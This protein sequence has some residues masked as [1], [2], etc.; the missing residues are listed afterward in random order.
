MK[1]ND[2]LIVI[3]GVIILILASIGIYFWEAEELVKKDLE[4]DD[5][6]KITGKLYDQPDAI[7]ISDSNPFYALSATPIAI[8]YC[9]DGIQHIIPMYIKNSTETSKSVLKVEGQ[10]GVEAENFTDETKTEK[11]FSLD[12]VKKY[13]DSSSAVILI[14]NDTTGYELGV[15]AVPIAS[16][17]SIPVIVTDEIDEDIKQVLG[18]LGVEYSLICGNLEGYGTYIKRYEKINDIINDTIEIIRNRFNHDVKY[19]T[20][21]NPRDAFCPEILESKMVLNE[22]DRVGSGNIF[23]SNVITAAT[24]EK[25]TYTITI[26]NDYKYALVKLDVINHEDPEFIEKFGD[27]LV[28]EGSLTGYMRTVASP[29]KR[30]A[31]GNIEYDRLHYET[32]FYDSG[33]EEFSVR[34]SSSFHTLDSAEFEVKATVENLEH[35]YYPFMKQF[36]SLAPYLTAARQGIVFAD[37]DFAFVADDDVKY[38]KQTIPG[39]TQ[40]MFNPNLIPVINQHVYENVHLPLNN[41]MSNIRQINNSDLKALTKNCKLDPFYVALI[42]DTTMIP[43]YYYRSPHSDPFDS[44]SKGGYGTNCPSDYI[45]GNIDPEMYS[46]R[47]YNKDDLENDIYS[48]FPELENIVGRIT[49]YDVQDANAL[50]L[51]TLFYDKVIESKH[52]TWKENALVMTGAGTEVQK[53]PILT[54]IQEKL[55]QHDPMK[56]PSGEK[57]FLI[58]RIQKNLETG[59]FVVTTTERGQSQRVGYSNEALW[60][61]KKDGLLN[62]LFF[63]MVAVKIRQGFDNVNSLF[64]LKWWVETLFSDESGVN[65]G[66]LQENSNLIICDQHAIWFQMEHGDIMMYALGGPKVIYEVLARYLPIPGLRFSSPLDSLGSYSVREVSNMD[67]GP[68]VMMIEGCGSGKIDGIPPTNT[69]ANSYLHAGVNAYIS[70]TTLSAFYGALE[71]RPDFRGGVGFGIIGYIK[72]ALNARRGI[73][74]P[75]YFNQYIFEETS[76]NLFKDKDIGTA[77]KEAKNMFLPAQFDETFRWTPPLSIPGSLPE[78]LS[79]DILS[80]MKESAGTDARYPVEKYCTIYQTN[81]LGDPAFNPYEPINQG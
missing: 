10:I 48:E 7:T 34:I 33:G 52:E 32:V 2:K 63:P 78:D 4:I 6:L 23:P 60:E 11:E 39:N 72:A 45:Y 40:V 30:D 26:P 28:V 20:I 73:Y 75:V 22:R 44:P 1:K 65:G 64:D 81:L 56:F 66:E 27:N 35:P 13:W 49:G 54:W 57:K 14:K 74:P 61:I 29:S 15:A 36:S 18:D 69:L 43:H 71:P 17:L 76:K 9:N 77:L 31:L 12:I 16:Y 50:I 41:L 59:D 55:G 24:S 58:Q 42:G 70:P 21:A 25:K 19:I 38:N 3:F 79:E 8:N 80:R 5:L 53:L 62:L 67:M 68:S 47:Q 51:R 37:S 46:L